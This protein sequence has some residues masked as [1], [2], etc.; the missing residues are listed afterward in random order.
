MKELTSRTSESIMNHYDRIMAEERKQFTICVG[1]NE[2]IPFGSHEASWKDLE[3]RSKQVMSPIAKSS[4][5]IIVPKEKKRHRFFKGMVEAL[6]TIQKHF[7]DK[8][9]T[10]KDLNQ[11]GPFYACCCSDLR[12]KGSIEIVQ[13]G[14]NHYHPTTYKLK[15]T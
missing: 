10:A 13:E 14:P 4:K 11:Y 6:Q 12:K 9:F 3:N 2:R 8:V 15:K 5:D 1:S 7:A